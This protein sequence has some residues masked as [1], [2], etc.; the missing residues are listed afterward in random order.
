MTNNETQIVGRF[1]DSPEGQPRFTRVG[2]PQELMVALMKTLPVDMIYVVVPH[3]DARGYSLREAGVLVLDVIPSENVKNASRQEDSIPA[4]PLPS[5]HQE[6]FNLESSFKESEPSIVEHNIK[7]QDTFNF[8]KPKSQSELLAERGLE[9]K[10]TVADV[11]PIK[12]AKVKS[13]K[14]IAKKEPV[15]SNDPN[16]DSWLKDLPPPVRSA[17]GKIS[18]RSIRTATPAE[19]L[20]ASVNCKI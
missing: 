20:A 3:E 6:S 1:K 18:I 2:S 13:R 15:I 8:D 7:T 19:A 11:S 12:K 14:K 4:Q 9:V 5:P 10:K 16:D 17:G